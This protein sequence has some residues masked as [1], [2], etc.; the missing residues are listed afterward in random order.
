MFTCNF[1][2][3]FCSKYLNALML[4]FCKSVDAGFP[5][6]ECLNP[7]RD[8]LC[9]KILQKRELFHF[10]QIQACSLLLVLEVFLHV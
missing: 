8:S 10:P 3:I 4:Y 1:F 2:L 7:S 5:G 6:L 9:Y